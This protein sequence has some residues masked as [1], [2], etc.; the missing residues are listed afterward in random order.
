MEQAYEW[1]P[2]RW[3]MLALRVLSLPAGRVLTEMFMQGTQVSLAKASGGGRYVVWNGSLKELRACSPS[4]VHRATVELVEAGYLVELP[5]HRVVN[6]RL[7]S[8]WMSPLVLAEQEA[9][10]LTEHGSISVF[11]PEH[12]SISAH[13]RGISDSGVGAE[14]GSISVFGPEPHIKPR[15]RARGKDHH[16]QTTTTTTNEISAA[17][18]C[19][20]GMAR[21]MTP[22]PPLSA[23][24]AAVA[25]GG[26][27]WA[28]YRD[29]EQALARFG[30][31]RCLVAVKALVGKLEAN[32]Y[33][34]KAGGFVFTTLLALEGVEVAP[35]TDLGFARWW[36][37]PESAPNLVAFRR[38]GAR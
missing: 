29:P 37:P 17:D 22:V 2:P 4:M 10:V 3:A 13:A 24:R 15:V 26:L 36:L 21:E 20:E 35:V 7:F 5:A 27:R 32:E 18:P 9:G 8:S 6:G 14:H 28:R 33:V 23:D 38:G 11:A 12:G 25:L 30:V 16:H 1:W 31:E 19:P 34:G